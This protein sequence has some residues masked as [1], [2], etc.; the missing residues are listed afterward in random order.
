MSKPYVD[1]AII[2]SNNTRSSTTFLIFHFYELTSPL[3]LL[4]MY[5]AF[6]AAGA[7][8]D[9]KFVLHYIWFQHLLL[10]AMWDH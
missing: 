6:V 9:S 1:N 10:N 3:H 5:R 8:Y 4:I 2:R 7:A